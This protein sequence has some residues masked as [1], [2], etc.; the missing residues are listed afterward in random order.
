M[1]NYPT[2]IDNFHQVLSSL[3]GIIN[4]CSNMDFLK[5]IQVGNLPSN[6]YA[7]CRLQLIKN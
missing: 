2:E 7:I 6:A 1:L 5:D 3:K 4:V